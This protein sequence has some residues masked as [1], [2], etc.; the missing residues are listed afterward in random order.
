MGEWMD[1]W[2]YGGREGR[3]DESQMEGQLIGKSGK[4]G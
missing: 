2:V 3:E 4:M 1:G